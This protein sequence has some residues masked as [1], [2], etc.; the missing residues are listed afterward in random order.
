MI[1]LIRHGLDDERYVG[2]YS[3]I[4]L[5]EEGIRQI[6][7]VIP[8]I[9]ELPINKIYT[10]DIKRAIET[11]NIINNELD[12]QIIKDKNLRELDKGLLNGKRKDLLTKEEFDNL[13]TNN[14][15]ER[16]SNGEAMTDLYNRV[17]DLLLNN[18]FDDKDNSLL[19][20]HRGFINMLYFILN[21]IELSMDK[22]RFGVTH[23]S[24][25]ELDIKNSK[26]KKLF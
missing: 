6:K 21:D 26:I 18:Y 20:T 10:S 4:S 22:E 5:T 19:V 8:K 23:S 1:Y 2:G 12:I 13:H 7:N 14:I 15:N 11:T 16:I 17:K 9:K 24:V 3:D 25:H